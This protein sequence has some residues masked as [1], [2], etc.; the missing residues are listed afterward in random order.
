MM[1]CAHKYKSARGCLGLPTASKAILFIPHLVHSGQ[2]PVRQ[3]QRT[4]H[5]LNGL[6]HEARYF[7]GSGA[8]D[9]VIRVLGI[10]GAVIAEDTS[11]RVWVQGM[12]DSKSLEPK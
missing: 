12:V 1:L 4:A 11:V 3:R 8:L 9:E 5:A 6:R 10:L 2:V 7:A